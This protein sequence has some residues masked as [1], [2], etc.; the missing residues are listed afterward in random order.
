MEQ[1][2]VEHLT[3]SYGNESIFSLKDITTTIP[4][5]QF[6]LIIGESGCGKT[7]LLR[8]LK[9]DYLPVGNRSEQAAIYINGMDTREMPQRDK[10]GLVGFVRQDPE[11]SQVMDKVWHELAF[12]LE[13]FGYPQEQMH[14]KVAEMVAFFGLEPIYDEKLCNLSGGQKQLVNLAAVMVMEP[15]VLVLDEPTSQLDP[16]AATQFFDM[17]ERIHREL[18]TTIVMTE[19]RLEE[20]YGL[21]D[22][23]LVMERGSIVCDDTPEQAA[24]YLW[25]QGKA[26]FDALPSSARIYLQLN[27]V[28]AKEK[29]TTAPMEC[30]TEHRLQEGYPSQEEQQKSLVCGGQEV[31]G[32][33]P[34]TVKDGRNWL[35]DILTRDVHTRDENVDMCTAD[36]MAAD[37]YSHIQKKQTYPSGRNKNGCG[38]KRTGVMHADELWF[39]Y[40]GKGADVL[41]ACSLSPEQGKITAILGGNGAGKSTLLHVLAGHYKPIRGRIHRQNGKIAMLPQNPQVLFAKDTVWEE[42]CVSAGVPTAADMTYIKKENSDMPG[43][44]STADVRQLRYERLDKLISTFGLQEVLQQHPFDLS[45]GQMQ[46]LALAK[47]ILAD[48]DILLLDEPGKGMDYQAKCE[49]GSVLRQLAD[50]GKTIVMV[51]HD[52]EFCAKYADV[53]GLFFDGHVVS[54]METR[55]FFLQNVFYTTAVCRMCRNLLDSVVTVEDVLS[56]FGKQEKKTESEIGIDDRVGEGKKREISQSETNI[57]CDQIL[58]NK[59]QNRNHKA[60]AGKKDS[61]DVCK[62]MQRQETDSKGGNK[63]LIFAAF[64]LCMAV[65][66]YLGHTV[67]QQR[68]YYFISLLLVLEAL[69]AFFVSFEREKPKLKEMMTISVMT[70]I[71]V[72]GRAAF[73]MVPNVKPMAA[74]TI[75][76][77]IGLGGEAGFLVGSLSM[78]VSNIFFGQGPWTPW[79]MA[80]MGLLGWLAG[81]FFRNESSCSWKKVGVICVFGFL[82]V[83]LV[84]GGIMNPAS[85][86]MYQEHV[87]R[88]MILSAY[89][90]GVPFDLLHAGGTVIFLLI[91]TRPILKK[92][93]RIQKGGN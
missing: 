19:H 7:T 83:L 52:V 10:A 28:S 81:I 16:V 49:M 11:T 66:I 41:K 14:R 82:S 25:Q 61:P 39:R 30:K 64:F 34:L 76:S 93:F 8:H 88:E 62:T 86:L 2:R 57:N 74:L 65:T 56:Y 27:S 6:V 45:G 26:M 36:S 48:Y 12:G 53:C 73:Y 43:S 9:V 46:K 55:S 32:Q 17:V 33:V 91:G 85:V 80:A 35:A 40:E 69:G 58:E 79:Q 38:E 59:G 29:T 51:S 31:A 4:K 70:A 60:D 3:F 77:G 50:N 54:L 75:L 71:T 37:M 22:R 63:I 23:V 68:K 92:L 24:V 15:E 89:A 90:M 47:L 20:V 1:I 84:Y 13:S 67:L 78:L 21:C 42:L 87:N 18:G 72:A 44:D 5:G